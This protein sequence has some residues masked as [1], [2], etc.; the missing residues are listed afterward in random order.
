MKGNLE[1]TI[2]QLINENKVVLD[3]FLRDVA[4][5]RLK[6]TDHL[7]EEFKNQ[8]CV[9]ILPGS[10]YNPNVGTPGVEVARSGYVGYWRTDCM[11]G[12]DDIYSESINRAAST[13][14]AHHKN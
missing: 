9:N 13:Q 2:K 1:L 3:A 14:G 12:M 5:V 4:K 10:G 6:N 7:I 11:A 8:S